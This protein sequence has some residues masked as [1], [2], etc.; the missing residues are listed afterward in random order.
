[1]HDKRDESDRQYH[2][3]SQLYLQTYLT[4]AHNILHQVGI[5]Q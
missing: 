3:T 1:M 2:S 4:I 5:R